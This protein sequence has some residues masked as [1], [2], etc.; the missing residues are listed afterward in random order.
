[1]CVC[2]RAHVPAH[3]NAYIVGVEH[4]CTA[5][6]LRSKTN[7]VELV[8]G[9]LCEVHALHP[10]VCGF[11]GSNSGHHVVQVPFTHQVIPQALF[12]FV[13]WERVSCSPGQLGFHY[14]AKASLELL[15]LLIPYC[16]SIEITM[17][18]NKMW[19]LWK[20]LGHR[21]AKSTVFLLSKL[22]LGAPN[23]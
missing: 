1:M 18:R 15:I 4:K 21:C 9:Q 6:M 11:Q 8:K 22:S 3:I 7:F 16:L 17:L 5:C 13:V 20:D 14:V 10:P 12:V 19:W 2:T 23:E